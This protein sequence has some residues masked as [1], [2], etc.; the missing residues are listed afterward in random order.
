M[1]DSG[2]TLSEFRQTGA[3]PWRMGADRKPEVLLVTGRRSSKWMDP[4]GLADDRKVPGRG[5]GIEAFEEAGVEGSID[6]QPLGTVAHLK[7]TASAQSVPR[8]WF[9]R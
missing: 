8:S 2:V 9:T 6:P 7:R 4:Q 5:A 1:R 3:L